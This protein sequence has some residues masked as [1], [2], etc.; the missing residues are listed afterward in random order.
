MECLPGR[1]IPP[2]LAC[3]LNSSF[4]HICCMLWIV[5]LKFSFSFSFSL[6][7]CPYLPCIPHG[8]L[9]IS[10]NITEPRSSI[11][12]S[13][14]SL[15]SLSSFFF[16]IITPYYVQMNCL[17]RI[18]QSLSY[19][20]LFSSKLVPLHTSHT[21]QIWIFYFFIFLNNEYLTSI[22]SLFNIGLLPNWSNILHKFI[23][24]YEQKY[25]FK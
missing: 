16:F 18:S 11:L 12:T 15:Y 8:L 9:F 20:V 25:L 3:S 10:F 23:P 7:Y 24:Y 22:V 1:R 6:T 5:F 19:S 13:S 2:H 4:Y 21:L 17:F 14:F